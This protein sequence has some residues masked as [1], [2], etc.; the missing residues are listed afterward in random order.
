MSSTDQNDQK[1][2]ILIEA[3][4]Y[5]IKDYS[6]QKAAKKIQDAFKISLVACILAT[7]LSALI[8]Y[9]AFS[10]KKYFGDEYF[11]YLPWLVP[12]LSIIFVWINLGFD[13][14]K[15]LQKM[16]VREKI[17]FRIIGEYFFVTIWRL[18]RLLTALIFILIFCGMLFGISFMV[19]L[20]VFFN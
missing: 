20:F 18:K 2:L 5:L 13:E 3:L 7:V 8:A 1:D 12:F 6:K 15:K 9:C 4:Q 17:R 10:L 16:N 19:T 11:H 14:V